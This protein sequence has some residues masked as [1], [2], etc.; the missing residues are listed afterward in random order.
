M[1][2]AARYPRV[3]IDLNREPDELDPDLVAD[4]DAMARVV[5]ATTDH[6][7][8]VNGVV[9]SAGVQDR[10]GAKLVLAKAHLL[11]SRLLWIWAD[12]G[13]AGP[14]GSWVWTTCNWFLG[15]VKRHEAVSGWQLL[16][17]RW[18]VERTFAWLDRS[19]RLSE[20][21][22]TLS[23]S[24]DYEF[25]PRTSETWVRVSMTH[26]MVRRLTSQRFS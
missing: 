18:I 15:I 12:G 8:P 19:R 11:W 14:L 5:R 16:P 7:G 21:P 4:P 9:H 24:K 26:L 17:H 13:Y 23:G 22:R 20:R 3:V 6:F 10:D 25:H 1:L 2:I